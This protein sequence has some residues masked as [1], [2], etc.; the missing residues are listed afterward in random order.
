M[1]LCTVQEDVIALN[2][3]ESTCFKN[4][5]GLCHVK[6]T[7]RQQEALLQKFIISSLKCQT[8]PYLLCPLS[9][10]NTHLEDYLAVWTDAL[11]Y[12]YVCHLSFKRKDLFFFVLDK[13]E[14]FTRAACILITLLG[15]VG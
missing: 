2:D 6:M 14:A 15:Y 5:S 4:E 1:L 9:M 13:L 7:E 10:F 11:N 3:T 12:A 8:M